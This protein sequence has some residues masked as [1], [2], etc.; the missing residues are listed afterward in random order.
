MDLDSYVT[1]IRAAL[2]SRG[3]AVSPAE[4]AG[5]PVLTGRRSDF[6]WR[7]FAVRLHTSVIVASFTAEEARVDNLDEFLKASSRWA[8]ANR[9]GSRMFG[10][11]SGAAAIAVAVLPDGADAA[12]V[13]WAARSHGQRFAAVAY[14]VAV[15]L[16]TGV[17]VQPRRMVVGGIF[18]GYLRAI[19]A[20]VVV[21]SLA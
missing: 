6:R 3:F 2:G 13:E 14:P 16:S 15:D 17:V 11:Q 7:W 12:V 10:L 21:G 5:R 8:V 9:R 20:E 18:T 19:V 4:V 1:A